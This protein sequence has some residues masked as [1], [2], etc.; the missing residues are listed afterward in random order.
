MFNLIRYYEG[1]I[2]AHLVGYAMS[3]ASYLPLAVKA[4]KNP[5]RITA[6]DNAVYMIHNAR[7]FTWGDHNDVLDYGKYLKGLSGII[8]RQY[9]K[10]TGKALDEVT[11]L[12]DDETFFF[13]DEMVEHGFVDA[14]VETDSDENRETALSTAQA[15]F[16]D[17]MAKMGEKKEEVKAD[18]EQAAALLEDYQP[19]A[20][21]AGKPKQKEVQQM[22][23]QQL[24]AENPAAK[25]EFDKALSDA[26]TEGEK[27]GTQAVEARI[28]AVAPIMESTEYPSPI[29]A[30]ALKALKG[31]T[32][33]EA[34]NTAVTVYDALKEQGL[35][36]AAGN[37]TTAAGDTPGQP[38]KAKTDGEPTSNENFAD[39]VAEFL[40]REA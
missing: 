22:A 32:S 24:L 10:R 35:A 16:S 18:F 1:N 17:A 29:K 36:S 12:M 7:G 4:R 37:E 33:V 20:A 3:M 31:D 14:I 34:L 28:T 40:G 38:P 5:G 25:A 23:L 26:R 21:T 39:E 27:A 6:E 9:V 11:K 8:A 2:H 15:V 19:P 13:G 30:T